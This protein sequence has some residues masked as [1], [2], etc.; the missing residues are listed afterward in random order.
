MCAKRQGTQGL[1]SLGFYNERDG[2]R[3]RNHRIDS[4]VL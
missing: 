1:K 3:T 4:P 2:A